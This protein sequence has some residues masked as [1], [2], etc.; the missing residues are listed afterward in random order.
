MTKPKSNLQASSQLIVDAIIEITNIVESMHQK[1][2][3]IAK[4]TGL[5]QKE[6]RQG[7]TGFV[8][9]SIRSLTEL[10]GKSIDAPLGVIS[11]SL[12]NPSI[13]P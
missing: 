6:R 11:Q 7:L 9:N 13:T 1:I 3:P 12:D 8:Y 2:N 10:V 4:L 5:S